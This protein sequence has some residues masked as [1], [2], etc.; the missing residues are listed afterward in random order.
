MRPLLLLRDLGVAVRFLT[1]FSWPGVPPSD[2]AAVARSAWAFPLAG[3]AVGACSAL[4]G[5]AAEPLFGKPLHVIAAVAVSA[6]VTGGL[7]LDGLADSA[8]ALFSWRPREKKLEILRDSRIGTMGALALVLVLATK[9]GA[10]LALG[11]SWWKGALIAPVYGRWSV[12]YG[13]AFFPPARPDGLGA[14]IRSRL[15]VGHLAPATLLALSVGAALSPALTALLA[16]VVVAVTHATARA[17]TRSLGG[18]TGDTYGALSEIAEVTVL[19]GWLAL[20]RRMALG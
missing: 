1:V 8:D 15:R 4:A 14:G 19:L 9:L 11:A 5:V 17:M 10:L 6:I 16:L 20:L 7:H 3:L 2:P 13:M 12:V 18:L